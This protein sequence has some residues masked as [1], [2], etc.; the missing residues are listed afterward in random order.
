MAKKSSKKKTEDSFEFHDDERVPKALHKKFQQIVELTQAYCLKELDEEYAVL[1][2]RSAARLARKRNSPLKKGY[3]KS[4]AAGIVADLADLNEILDDGPG[5]FSEQE[6]ADGFGVARSTLISK[7]REI[8]KTY[9]NDQSVAAML[10]S[11]TLQA[12][13]NSAYSVLGE[14]SPD[15][16]GFALVSMIAN[17]LQEAEPVL[18]GNL[19]QRP[20]TMKKEPVKLPASKTPVLQLKVTLNDCHPP[21]WRRFLVHY[22]TP[23]SDLHYTIQDVMGW[24]DG[25]FHIFECEPRRFTDLS[26]E[27]GY[28]GL[29]DEAS[30][31]VGA[32]LKKKGDSLQYL[33]DFG[34][35][36]RHTIVLEKRLKVKDGLPLCIEGERA[37]PLEDCG[38][39]Y[40]HDR[41]LDFFNT[42]KKKRDPDLA[43]WIP[44]DYDPSF[45]DIE[46]VNDLLSEG[47]PGAPVVL[48]GK[49]K[50]RYSF[51]LN[52][53]GNRRLRD[54]FDCGK[55]LKVLGIQLLIDAYQ[56]GVQCVSLKADH[57]SKCDILIVNEDQLNKALRQQL[58]ADYELEDA[59]DFEALSKDDYFVVGT[60]PKSFKKQ[61]SLEDEALEDILAMLSNFRER[62]NILGSSPS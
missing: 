14:P 24:F 13:M 1:C 17:M 42:P 46:E 47:A 30:M 53:S 62:L 29:E 56:H 2:R 40:G 28:D 59:D 55:G 3:A 8:A 26:F 32:L 18:Q 51:L 6:I 15:A 41:I 5:S 58:M 19:P 60:L 48:I 23:L 11:K 21:I 61:G 10:H 20:P 33:Y 16:D 44:D 37:C 22:S 57:C 27:L 54:C 35:D 52:C 43:D 36:W 49:E 34:D 45:F 9:T 7:A 25:H 4:L 12:Q 31:P 38:G 50:P 39:I